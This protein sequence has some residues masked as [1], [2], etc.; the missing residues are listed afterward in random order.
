MMTDGTCVDGTLAQD[1]T[2]VR[3]CVSSVCGANMCVSLSV[4]V[5]SLSLSPSLSLESMEIISK[6]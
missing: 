4:C 3:A 2:Q 1:A 6:T 5:C